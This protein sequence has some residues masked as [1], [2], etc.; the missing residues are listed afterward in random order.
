M[1]KIGCVWMTV[2]VCLILVACGGKY[3]DAE[4]T[5]NDYA[6]AMEEYADRMERADNVDAVVAAMNQYTQQMRTLV[7]RLQEMSQK[8][9]EL[10]SARLN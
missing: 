6:D 7:P 1:R 5:L 4:S 10:A 3:D 9:P 8:F 2:T